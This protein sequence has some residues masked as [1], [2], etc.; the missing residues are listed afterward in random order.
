VI[1]ARALAA[2]A[3]LGVAAAV[4]WFVWIEAK[5][6]PGFR[7]S[8]EFF[9][10]TVVVGGMLV[11]ASLV[12]TPA[13]VA[14]ALAGDRER[15][16]TGLLLTTR[17]NAF[18]IVAGRLAGK[19][20][21]VGMVLLAGFPGV[22]LL[23]ALAGLGPGQLAL[24]VLLPASV[25]VGGA[26]LS[27]ASA[28]VARRGRD[29]LVSVYL[30]DVFLLAVPM[31]AAA[32][33]SSELLAWASAFNPFTGLSDLATAAG[34][35]TAW[36]SVGLWLGMGA[37]GVA[38]ASWRLRPSCLAT[39]DGARGGRRRR[40]VVPPVDERRPVLWKELF[41]ERAATLGRFGTWAGRLLVFALVAGTLAMAAVLW[42]DAIDPSN[43][44]RAG[45]A[46]DQLAFWVG[47][48]GWLLVF[49]I[50]WAAGLRAAVSIAS[51]RERGTWDALLTSP[52]K[53]GEIVRA[54]LWGSLFALRWLVCAAVFSW[55]VAAA[56]GAIPWRDAIRWGAD[57]AVVGAFMAA[58]GVR[59]SLVCR[60][61]ARA[62]TVTAGVWLGAGI[63]AAFL[64]I[65][66]LL[67]GLLASNLL[68][69]AAADLGL[70]PPLT[71]IWTPISPVIAWP[72]A[73]LG[74]YVVAALLVVIDTALRFDRLAGRM[75]GGAVPLAFD[76]LLYGR[77]TA[78]GV[79]ADL[80]PPDRVTPAARPAA[81]PGG[82]GTG[83]RAASAARPPFS[84]P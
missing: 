40:G 42:W 8:V 70:V 44:G 45:W 19:L 54:K 72:L 80:G 74:C 17:V 60:T 64:A 75:T 15:G 55:L 3:V 65:L 73:F 1:L 9:V 16:A 24:L 48:T 69:L 56:L 2:L 32:L 38:F 59:A 30:V 35:G 84:S 18:E 39:A 53:A 33:P 7:P 52:L 78:E 62:M 51:E 71:S 12:L 37:A 6:R 46:R 29:A 61:S 50:E 57:V 77:A 43:S 11:A 36:R 67:A 10:G 83:G 47:E 22:V 58:V 63:L 34:T 4:L 81:S 41:I 49:L 5:V 79:G 14:G 31:L 82:H 20:A 21:Q 25:A 66:L 13:L 27:A 68:W 28:C 76:R 26:G 23:A